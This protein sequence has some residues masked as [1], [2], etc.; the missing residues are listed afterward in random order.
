MNRLNLLPGVLLLLAARVQAQ[1]PPPDQRTQLNL[2]RQTNTASGESQRNENVRINPIDTNT[3]RELSRRIGATATIVREFQAD[4]NY[5]ASE[6][7]RNLDA[8]LHL[9]AAGASSK[10][11]HG[12]IWENHENS[13]TSAR[14]FFQVGSVL[15]ARDND[16]GFRLSSPVWRNISLGLDGS[17]QKSRGMVNG[18]VLVPRADE[19][20]P[21]T[22]D[23]EAY[24]L[25]ASWL[26]GYP[27]V[28]PNL[29]DLDARALNTNAPQKVDTNSLG[30]R[31]DASL[32]Q[33]DSLVL[34][35]QT[36]VQS[37]KAF[38]LVAGQNPD[39]DLHNHRA[40]ATWRHVFRPTLL[41]AFSASYDR[42]TT[43]IRADPSSPPVRIN[44]TNVI[45][46]IGND[47]DV[48]ILRT[49]NLFRESGALEGFAANHHWHVGGEIARTQMNSMEQES[50]RPVVTFQSN[51]G[52][53]AVTNLRK[54]LPISYNVL[55]GDTYRGYRTWKMIAYADDSWRVTD[56][57]QVQIGLRY[58]PLLRPTEVNHREAMPFGCSC[59]A[60]APRVA[61]SYRLP[62]KWGVLRSGYGLDYGQMFVATFGQVR[63]N[64]P[65]AARL[66]INTP[67]LLNP[68]N[69][70]TIRDLGPNFRSA[71]YQLADNLGLPYEHTYNASWEWRNSR[72]VQ[73]QIGYVGSRAHRL[74]ET[75]YNNRGGKVAD[76]SQIVP[77]TVNARRADQTRYDIFRIHNGAKSYFDAAR[78]TLTVPSAHGFSG[79]I[80]Y[81]Y[82]K[83]I[84]FGT[85][86]TSTVA[87]PNT[88]QGRSP[89]ELFVHDTM[90][91]LASFDQPHAL[92][93]RAN[94]QT[95][96]LNQRWARSLVG[97]WSLNGVW[98]LKSG[99][100]FTVETGS[101]GP[102]FGN[103]DG[104]NSDRP[105]LQDPSILGRT[106]G[107][108][109]TAVAL[110]PS[111]AFGYLKPSDYTGNLGRDTF[112]RGKITNV[113]SSVE[114]TWALPRDWSL[115]LRAEAVNLFNTPQFDTPVFLLSSPTFGKITN[116]LNGGRVFHFRLQLQ[117]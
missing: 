89:S 51:F 80:S 90:K 10:R 38:Q 22:T 13:V 87:G 81:W 101:D 113:N 107:N 64:L 41:A 39:S 77:S 24:K 94:Y 97:R 2:A 12:T 36:T 91:G 23:P 79:E 26:A 7:G 88:R 55:L 21:L 14:S 8:P 31:L 115:Q 100:P 45:Q 82:S 92:L 48:P 49:Q 62:G 9:P 17:Q 44:V 4:R 35:F 85:D 57:F 114:R 93:L 54:G 6:Y 30:E 112:R 43:S 83:A 18:N 95:P 75:L 96:Q 60:L 68:L 32:G 33:K 15:P 65:N 25:I 69:G 50:L 105:F 52:N 16:Y 71:Y 34:R 63:M 40:T 70:L 3:E 61:L 47:T 98:L 11:V 103:V 20:T 29:P 66:T 1:T 59:G 104:Q 78:V 110:L 67:N 116:T 106:I 5:F 76:V 58:E 37:V 108:P 53:D 56:R 72:G 109:D 86:Y 84:D 74:F 99:T 27:A 73:L 46:T 42:T 117:F 28:A 19:R 111:S 102:G